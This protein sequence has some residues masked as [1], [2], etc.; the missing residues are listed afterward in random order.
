MEAGSQSTRG[1]FPT[2]DRYGAIDT[3]ESS[4]DT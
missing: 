1:R 4:R 3:S 2:A